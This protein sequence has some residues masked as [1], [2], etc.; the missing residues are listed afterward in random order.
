MAHQV[1][2]FDPDAGFD[3]DGTMYPV[4]TLEFDD[5][6]IAQ[7]WTLAHIRQSGDIFSV[8]LAPDPALFETL[9]DYLTVLNT[10]ARYL[11]ENPEGGSWISLLTEDLDHWAE[12]GVLTPAH[13]AD[14][15][16]GCFEREMEKAAWAA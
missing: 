6:K 1:H 10:R 7:C 3:E 14:Y 16:D 2:F 8:S 9:S 4:A 15:L 5:W 13:M 11:E 12:I